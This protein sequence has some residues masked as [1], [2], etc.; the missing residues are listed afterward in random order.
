MSKSVVYTAIFGNYDT[1]S[2][3]QAI[4]KDCDYICFTDDYKLKSDVWGIRVIDLPIPN[5]YSRSN[6]YI[7]INPHEFLSEYEYSLYLDGNI[8]LKGI[9]EIAGVLD[10]CSIAIE[11]HPC[12]DCIYKEAIECK[13]LELGVASEIDRQIEDYRDIDFPEHAGLWAN[14]MIFRRHN[15]P[16]LIEREREWWEHIA[17]YSWRDQISF[18]VAFKEYPIRTLPPYC[19]LHSQTIEFKE[20][21]Q[22]V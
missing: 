15:E 12:R 3:P 20:H 10:D 2:D 14:W 17:K 9:L 22:K 21:L 7:K 6:R 4:S 18:P 19:L 5:D 11:E 8:V 13:R 16:D 1:L